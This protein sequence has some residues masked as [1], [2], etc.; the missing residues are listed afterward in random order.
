MIK[1]YYINF[2]VMNINLF[3]NNWMKYYKRGFLTGIIVLSFLC[4]IDQTLQS[5]IFFSKIDSI[6]VLFLTLSFIFFGAVFC[7]IISL[8]ILLIISLITVIKN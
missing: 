2:N 3:K 8:I 4:F 5:S 1:I 6:D 7:G